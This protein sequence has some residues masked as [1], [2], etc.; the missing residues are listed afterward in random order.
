MPKKQK[1]LV[2]RYQRRSGG[3]GGGWQ[4]LNTIELATLFHF[5][6]ADARTPVLSS[7]G[8]R[9][10]EAPST[11][12]LASSDEPQLQNWKLQNA[13]VKEEERV[14][15]IPPASFSVPTPMSPTEHALPHEPEDVPP[16]LP[17]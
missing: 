11:L 2:S 13:E 17:M 4:M 8:A 5:P 6:A 12:D 16:N 7:T 3:E 14:Q 1:N 15:S 9:R 10:A